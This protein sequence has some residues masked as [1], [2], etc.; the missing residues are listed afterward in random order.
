VPISKELKAK[1]LTK[2]RDPETKHAQNTLVDLKTG[3]MCCLGVL[4]I[5]AGCEVKSEPD[6]TGSPYGYLLTQNNEVKVGHY[7][8]EV[9]LT[10]GEIVMLAE[11]NDEPGVTDFSP[12][13]PLIEALPETEETENGTAAA[14]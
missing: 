3:G 14:H 2:L 6:P 9:G 10:S 13:L 4:G 7:G 1:W 12:V 11:A 8:E 5:V